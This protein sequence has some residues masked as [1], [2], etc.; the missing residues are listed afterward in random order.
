MCARLPPSLELAPPLKRLRQATPSGTSDKCIQRQH[1]GT[2]DLRPNNVHEL[3]NKQV[4][5]PNR[6]KMTAMRKIE[7]QSTPAAK[8][9]PT[10]SPM[11][12]V[13]TEL[14]TKKG[15]KSNTVAELTNSEQEAGAG[16]GNRHSPSFPTEFTCD[17][18]AKPFASASSLAHHVKRVHFTTERRYKCVP[19]HKNFR[20]PSHLR[21]HQKSRECIQRRA[22]KLEIDD[23]AVAQRSEMSSRAAGGANQT[24]A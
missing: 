2:G 24:I 19:C 4:A 16:G 11:M 17:F 7:C 12:P 18:C 23:D 5:M 3:T 13:E 1:T 15:K 14:Q 22:V 8:S 20:L 10:A 6:Q 21:Q 9:T